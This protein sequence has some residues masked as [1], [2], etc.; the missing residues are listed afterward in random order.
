[1]LKINIPAL[2]VV[3]MI[4]IRIVLI[5]KYNELLK[6]VKDIPTTL[7]VVEL[8]KPADWHPGCPQCDYSTYPCLTI[9]SIIRN[10][11]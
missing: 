4:L 3:W 6:K 7:G 10:L 9:E 2:L 8:H 5:M 11:P 1:M